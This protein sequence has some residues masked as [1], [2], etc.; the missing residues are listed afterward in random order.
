MFPDKHLSFAN[1][2]LQKK[3]STLECNGQVIYK[4][5]HFLPY[6]LNQR[7]MLWDLSVK[8][9]GKELIPLEPE[10]Y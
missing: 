5:K 2:N 3:T 8:V 9:Q 4:R 10:Q 7:G 6:T 1:F